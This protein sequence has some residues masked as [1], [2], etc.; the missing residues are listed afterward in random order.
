MLAIRGLELGSLVSF[1]LHGTCDVGID[2]NLMR[3][4]KYEQVRLPWSRRVL[5]FELGSRSGW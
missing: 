3:L 5:R 4:F 2:T 1:A